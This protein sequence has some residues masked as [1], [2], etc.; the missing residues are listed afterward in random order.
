M[1]ADLPLEKILAANKLIDA[2]AVPMSERMMAV[3]DPETGET[4]ILDTASVS[5]VSAIRV[6]GERR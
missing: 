3:T 6:E 5:F 4:V 2:H 1:N